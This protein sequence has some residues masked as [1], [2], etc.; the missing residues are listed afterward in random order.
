[1]ATLG[2]MWDF[3]EENGV[4]EDAEIW[5]CDE[6]RVPCRVSSLAAS[7][8]YRWACL[9]ST[10]AMFEDTDYHTPESMRAWFLEEDCVCEDDFELEAVV[11]A[12][13]KARPADGFSLEVV[14]SGGVYVIFQED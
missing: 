6:N 2:D 9:Q 3:I 12:G 7:D 14:P 10:S 5:L 8:A 13:E 4:S 1:M 11:W